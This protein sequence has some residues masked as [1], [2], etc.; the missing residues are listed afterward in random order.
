MTD[1]VEQT[2]QA[3]EWAAAGVPLGVI[4]DRLG[5]SLSTVRRRLGQDTKRR[6]RGRPRRGLVE[7]SQLVAWRAQGATWQEIADQAGISRSSARAR[8][9]RAI[10][11]AEP[12]RGGARGM[13]RDHALDAAT[14]DIT[15]A[16]LSGTTMEALAERYDVTPTMI[17]S[18]LIRAGELPWPHWEPCPDYLT[19]EGGRSIGRRVRT[20]WAR[21]RSTAAIAGLTGLTVSEV[22]GHVDGAPRTTKR[23]TA[24]KATGD[25][26]LTLLEGPGVTLESLADDLGLDVADLTQR[27]DHALQRLPTGEHGTP[28]MADRC[29]CPM[30]SA[31]RDRGLTARQRRSRDRIDAVADPLLRR[32][33]AGES[34]AEATAD[35]GLT[36]AAVRGRAQWDDTWAERLE[37][38]LTAGRPEGLPHGTLT[39]YA[40]GCRCLD[41]QNAR[42]RYAGQP[43]RRRT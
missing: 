6:D 34:L 3:R 19:A 33:A 4:A 21:G 39:G 13:P 14:E 36:V 20:L 40:R 31:L 8:H 41:C 16:W 25:A 18:R 5:V 29:N 30:C 22:T 12:N 23:P 7:D 43:T 38:A 37:D 9:Q 28:D 11:A 26:L 42:R 1:T 32:L 15:A 24:A 10:G 2:R 27:R 35:L 17:R